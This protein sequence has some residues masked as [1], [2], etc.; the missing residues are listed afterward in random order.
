MNERLNLHL[1]DRILPPKECAHMLGV[2]L[3]LLSDT[4]EYDPLFPKRKQ[5][6]ERKFGWLYSD[7][8]EFIQRKTKEGAICK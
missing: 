3:N 5:I 6:T 4:I 7:I 2:S 1:N 8:L